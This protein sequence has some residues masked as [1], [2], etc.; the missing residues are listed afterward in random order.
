MD[1]KPQNTVGIHEFILTEINKERKILLYSRMATDKYRQI[2]RE[3]QFGNYYRS[4]NPLQY[5]YLE[6]PMDGEAWQATVH[7]VTK[8]QTQLSDFIFTF[9]EV[10]GSGC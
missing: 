1:F 10:A 9:R 5:S 2:D 7:G 8:S 6:N 4:G 3:S